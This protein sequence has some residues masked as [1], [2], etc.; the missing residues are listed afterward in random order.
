MKFKF[1]LGSVFLACAFAGGAQAATVVNRTTDVTIS[2]DNAN[3][4]ANASGAYALSVAYADQAA[5]DE[6]FD[7]QPLSNAQNIAFQSNSG[8]VTVTPPAGPYA[9]PDVLLDISSNGTAGSWTGSYTTAASAS[10][11]LLTYGTLGGYNILNFNGGGSLTGTEF[12]GIGFYVFVYIKGNW[13]TL[14]TSTGD[15][16]YLG[17]NAGFGAPS[18]TYDTGSDTTTLEVINPNYTDGESAGI[19]F[20][21]IGSSAVPEPA[22]WGLMLAGFFGL[23][24]ALRLARRKGN[25]AAIA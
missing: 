19:N 11:P 6:S 13:T 8:G 16:D 22:T 21:L 12:D 17:A 18:L 24:G 2:F 23:G 9:P 25:Q 15:L 3:N 20:D 5:F 14:G 7:F 4:F 1:L 10:G